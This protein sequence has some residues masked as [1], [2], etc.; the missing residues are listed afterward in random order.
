[1]TYF[2][3]E[4]IEEKGTREIATNLCFQL[5]EEVAFHFNLYNLNSFICS[6]L[7]TES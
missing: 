3:Y 2:Y 7:K 1:M 5:K 4:K 6:P